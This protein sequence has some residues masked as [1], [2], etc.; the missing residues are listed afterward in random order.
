MCG[1]KLPLQSLQLRVLTLGPRSYAGDQQ[2]IWYCLLPAYFQ[3]PNSF[4]VFR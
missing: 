3:H 1:T 4:D 2:D